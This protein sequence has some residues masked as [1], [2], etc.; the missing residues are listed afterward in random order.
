MYSRDLR[1]LFEMTFHNRRKKPSRKKDWSAWCVC[2][3]GYIV[4][5]ACGD[6]Q[7]TRTLQRYIH[8]NYG[9]ASLCARRTTCSASIG[10]FVH[11]HGHMSDRLILRTNSNSNPYKM[12]D[13]KALYLDHCVYLPAVRTSIPYECSCRW[14]KYCSSLWVTHV[15]AP[16]GVLYRCWDGFSFLPA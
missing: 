13:W 7:A 5:V 12:T 8:N 6:S 15:A 11:F 10:L 4:S 14:Y 2:V 1:V 3:W 16:S 9:T